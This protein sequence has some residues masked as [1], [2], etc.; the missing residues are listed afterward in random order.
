MTYPE[1]EAI[2]IEYCKKYFTLPK[3]Y[4]DG[5]D[6]TFKNS[7]ENID[8]FILLPAGFTEQN[9]NECFG[10]DLRV[11]SKDVLSG[12]RTGRLA[13]RDYFPS[14][15]SSN[16][17][18]ELTCAHFAIFIPL[19]VNE[20]DRYQLLDRLFGVDQI[21][22]EAYPALDYCDDSV[23]FVT[24]ARIFVCAML[25]R[26]IKNEFPTVSEEVS[27]IML[28]IINRIR[29][30]GITALALEILDSIYDDL[31]LKVT[32]D[33]IFKLQDD[34]YDVD[35]SQNKNQEYKKE[36]RFRDL[37]AMCS[38][39]KLEI[40][41]RYFP[42][43]LEKDT[44]SY[45][46]KYLS[47]TADLYGTIVSDAANYTITINVGFQEEENDYEHI[48]MLI[49][50]KRSKK[51]T[52]NDVVAFSEEII[53]HFEVLD[54]EHLQRARMI[55][56]FYISE[57][58]KKLLYEKGHN[59][60][61]YYCQ[62]IWTRKIYKQGISEDNPDVP[63]ES[64]LLAECLTAERM[65]HHLLYEKVPVIKPQFIMSSAAI[66]KLQSKGKSQ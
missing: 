27:P 13:F 12:Y 5:I 10:K 18:I 48:S 37:I 19:V 49:H 57:K 36:I 40:A 44:F 29:T 25:E 32:S 46:I 9:R 56:T 62:E 43:Y 21:P 55:S 2:F 6:G 50:F 63:T 66:R 28:D 45:L 41:A 38:K 8:R 65:F 11:L 53:R 15:Y 58:F 31:F 22:V 61:L 24:L 30:N 20:G 14:A 7:A 59:S 52:F 64:L 16:E 51:Y 39:D 1:F 54:K 35:D 47:G 60:A 33:T 34:D 17:A 4:Y 23:F 26:N 42:E 3:G